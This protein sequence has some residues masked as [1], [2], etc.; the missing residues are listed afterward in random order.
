LQVTAEKALK[1]FKSNLD[2]DNPLT[3]QRCWIF[4]EPIP[5]SCWTLGAVFIED[6]ILA[7]TKRL[8]HKLMLFNLELIAF[9]FF[10]FILLFRADKGGVRSLWAV[11]SS[12]AFV[13]LAGIGFIWHL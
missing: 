9:F 4:F 3:G 6:E 10:L 12:T 7:D 11:S 2:F 1:G 5:A 8:H 13:L